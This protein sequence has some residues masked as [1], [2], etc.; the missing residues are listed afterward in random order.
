[1][2]VSLVSHTFSHKRLKLLSA[3]SKEEFLQYILI[4][5]SSQ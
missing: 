4:I 3:L 1:M 5:P 2:R